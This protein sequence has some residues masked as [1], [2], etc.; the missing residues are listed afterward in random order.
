MSLIRFLVTH[1]TSDLT[2]PISTFAPCPQSTESFSVDEHP[3]GKTTLETLAK[4]PSVFKKDGTV[5][6]G[7]ASGICDGAAANIIA[8]EEALKRYG[9]KPLARVVSYGITACEPSI[10]GVSIWMTCWARSQLEASELLGEG[11]RSWDSYA[12]LSFSPLRLDQSKLSRWPSLVLLLSWMTLTCS[13]WTRPSQL[14]SS[15]FKRSSVY[16]TRRPTCSVVLLVSLEFVTLFS[17]VFYKPA[18]LLSSFCWQSFSLLES[19]TSICSS[20]SSSW[21]FWSQDHCQ[22]DSQPTSSRQEVRYWSC[23][24]WRWSRYRNRLGKVLSEITNRRIC[25]SSNFVSNKPLRLSL[26]MC[27]KA[28]EHFLH[29]W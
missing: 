25:S 1:L 2:F 28:A 3:R 4:L 5:T 14:N 15:V 13:K 9:L 20:R 10:M 16:Q 8:G 29:Y 23:L 6:A 11:K 7:N 17:L 21:S 19:P 18:S 22:L 12:F 24:Y 26:W 27:F